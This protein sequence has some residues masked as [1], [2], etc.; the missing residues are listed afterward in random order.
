MSPRTVGAL[1]VLA[2]A[3]LLQPSTFGQARGG[4]AGSAGGAGTG[5]TT[6]ATTSTGTTGATTGRLPGTTASPNGTTT[7]PQTGRQTL[8]LIGRVVTEDGSAPDDTVTIERVCPGSVR[9][10]GYTDSKGYFS[11]EL[12][13]EQNVFQDAS[14]STGYNGSGLGGGGG[15]MGGSSGLG[16]PR[17]SVASDQRYAACELR[18]RAS[19]YRSQTVSL[20][21]RRPLDDPNIGTILLHREGRDEGSTVSAVSLSAPHDARRAFE[22][23]LQ[24]TKKKRIDE[25]EKDY[26][27]AVEIYPKFATAWNELGRIQMDRG[28]MDAARQSFN[29]AIK[30]DP[31]YVHPYLQ[32]SL[33][34][35]KAARWQELA[36]VTAQAVK[37]DPFDYPEAFL[38]NGAANWNLKH[39]DVA[40][41]SIRQAERLDSQHRHPQIEYLMGLVLL[42]HLDYAGAVEHL[43]TY[44]KLAP[45]ADDAGKARTQ[46][47]LAEKQL[48]TAATAKQDR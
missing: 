20:A 43:Q 35:L 15:G 19:G 36:D 34:A 10:E 12:G 7:A 23:G 2:A 32:L 30:A 24:A 22:H 48:Q 47:A 42:Q 38:F 6:G 37:L 8:F 28:Q 27:K 18:A 17:G 9:S 29:T 45:D 46:L 5:S 33:I 40:E 4:A 14:E 26:Q 11:I 1:T 25:A 41:K 44:L 21:N 31:K 16:G 3:F 39:F 13:N